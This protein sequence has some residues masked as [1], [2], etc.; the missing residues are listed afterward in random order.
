M[1]FRSVR[2]LHLRL[3]DFVHAL[4]H[5]EAD[6]GSVASTIA[7]RVLFRR[8]RQVIAVLLFERASGF[9]VLPEETA[10]AAFRRSA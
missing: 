5:T 8:L 9:A 3:K 1:L 6:A 2:H 4:L 10:S 7:G